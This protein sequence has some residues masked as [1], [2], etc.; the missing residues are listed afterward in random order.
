MKAGLVPRLTP[1]GPQKIKG[2]PAHPQPQPS[3]GPVLYQRTPESQGSLCLP[4]L[5]L[6]G[7]FHEA[8]TAT[9]SRLRNQCNVI[10]TPCHEVVT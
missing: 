10:Q 8:L 9:T 7:S 2:S 5:P 6:R 1:G 3:L 4:S